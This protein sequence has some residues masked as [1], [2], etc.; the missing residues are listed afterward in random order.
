MSDEY[1]NAGTYRDRHGRE[2]WRF[3]RGGKTISLPH[4]PGHPEFEEAYRAAIEG[5]EPRKATVQPLPTASLPKSLRA[6]WRLV[7]SANPDW[8][9]L[10]P[11]TRHN[12]SAIA[13]TFLDSEVTEGDPLKWG[14]VPVENLRRRH[15]KALLA[16]RSDRPHAARHLLVVIRKMILAGLDEEWI[17]SDPTYR[18][19][20]RPAT[21]GWRAWTDDERALF[22]KRWP[23]GT[24][25]RLAYALA[26]WLGNRRSDVAALP[27]S[28][29]RG[30]TIILRQIKTGREL[31]LSITPMLAEALAQT[32]LS[33]PTI[34]KTMFGEPFSSKSLTGRMKDWT[35]SAGLP[36]GCT[37]HGLRKTLGG[38]LADS[39]ATTREIMDTLGH[40][41][42]KHAELYTKS[43]NQERLA[44]AGLGKVTLLHAERKKADG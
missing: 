11:V 29:I 33:G 39:G 22:E 10:D 19:K 18:L 7:V 27:V 6:A 37:M 42:L 28:A 8:K 16:D 30:D 12:Q 3:R 2:R 4:K 1:P 38:M 35:K 15:M 40:T 32:D 31:K 26:L 17:E 20:Y 43:A 44:R 34:L 36:A 21:K 14:E 9:Q 5:R 41:N 24:T 23:L 13:M 25:P